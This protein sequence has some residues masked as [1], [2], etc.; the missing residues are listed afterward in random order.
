METVEPSVTLLSFLITTTGKFKTFAT[1][2]ASEI[3][4][5]AIVTTASKSW[6]IYSVAISFPT[7]FSSVGFPIKSDKINNLRVIIYLFLEGVQ[8]PLQSLHFL[9]LHSFLVYTLHHRL[10]QP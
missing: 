2:L 8:S 9:L 3:P 5:V 6:S 7:L 1:A 10:L 4:F